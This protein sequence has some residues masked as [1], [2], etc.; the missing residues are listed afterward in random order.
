MTDMQWFEI[1]LFLAGFAVAM[2]ATSFWGGDFIY[3]TFYKKK[4]NQV[5]KHD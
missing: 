4:N 2:V 5:A 1:C 3:R